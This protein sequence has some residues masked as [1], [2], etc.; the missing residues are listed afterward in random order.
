MGGG[1]AVLIMILLEP[2]DLLRGSVF[3]ERPLIV[4][5]GTLPRGLPLVGA[6]LLLS[7]SD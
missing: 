6:R 3:I 1:M 2:E 4:G 7:R 5:S